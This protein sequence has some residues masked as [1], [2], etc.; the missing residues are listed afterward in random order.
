MMNNKKISVY[1]TCRSCISMDYP[2][3]EAIRSAFPFADEIVVLDSTDKDDGTMEVL[4]KL[5]DENDKV[6]VYHVDIPWNAPNYGIYDGLAKAE[7]RSKC[8]GDYL[9]QADMDEIFEE[10]FGE[11][12]LEFFKHD[13]K[14]FN[15]LLLFPV[16]EFWGS[17]DKVRIDV[18]WYK[19]RISPNDP[20]IT[21]GI[22][23]HLRWYKD[24]LLYAKNGTDGC[25]L[26]N[27]QTGNCILAVEPKQIVASIDRK[28]NNSVYDKQIDLS[29]IDTARFL[30]IKNESHVLKYQ[31][32]F[33]D[34]IEFLPTVYHFSWFSIASKIRKYRDFWN[35]SW[36]TLY[37]EKQNKPEGW[38]PFFDKPLSEVSEEEIEE[39]A[40]Q[41]ATETGGHIFHQRY[42]SGITP[43]TNHVSLN[44]EIPEIMNVWMEEHKV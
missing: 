16:V 36:L 11:K 13:S 5:M 22:P 30:S 20:N 21:H 4:E 9:I 15:N 39:K 26:I 6:Q 42:V 12:L 2:F 25:N 34:A 23:K 14:I 10:N 7:A 33:Q 27:S 38:N 43:K 3:E 32:L 19:E 31:N 37:G 35:D 41:L 17:K 29:D 28:Y 40:Q 24:N 1:F 8:T 44:V 18:N